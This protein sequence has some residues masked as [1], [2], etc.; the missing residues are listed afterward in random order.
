MVRLV[1]KSSFTHSA[2]AKG[3]MKYI[4]SREG[5]E[6]IEGSGSATKKQKQYIQ[7]L[8]KNDPQIVD[9]HEYRDYLSNP[10]TANAN[11]LISIVRD[12]CSPDSPDLQKYMKYIATRPGVE[13]RGSHGLFSNTESVDLKAAL[14]SLEAFD[15]NVWTLIYSLRRE[16]AARLGFDSVDRWRTLICSHQHE[17]AD[18]L[19]IPPNRLHWY[20]AFHNE[21]HHPHIHMMLWSEDNSGYLSKKGIEKMRSFMT[22]DIFEQDLHELYVQKDLNYRRLRDE[23]KAQMQAA[24][25]RMDTGTYADPVIAEKMAM[26][27]S[28]LDNCTG[29]KQYGYLPKP[30]KAIVDDIV[31]TL[32][33]NEDVAQ[34][35]DAWCSLQETVEHYYHDHEIIRVPL[36][37]RKEFRAIKNMVIMEAEYIRK[38]RLE[39][40]DFKSSEKQ[41]VPTAEVSSHHRLNLSPAVSSQDP[42]VLS[43]AIR[44]VHHMSNVFRN[45]ALPPANPK[46]LRVES[47]RRKKLQ[48][49]RIA[50][51]HKPKD[52][53][54]EASMELTQ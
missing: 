24:L 52:H 51:G 14:H 37:Q 13:K 45:N 54:E 10:T 18:A 44:L 39:H 53:E 5:V 19:H 38:R 8:L 25:A 31:D 36:S 28:A 20:A 2:S 21:G 4:A 32:S 40:S 34:C 1:Q 3:Y 26:L 16:D 15:G 47:K 29:K 27:V 42:L 49:K 30:V 9:L 50:H 17:F 41:Y 46:G 33:Q 23:A 43:S 12:F 6:T 35:Y 11:E 48:Q 7:A 22:N